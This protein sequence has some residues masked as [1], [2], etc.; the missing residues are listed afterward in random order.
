MPKPVEAAMIG[1]LPEGWQEKMLDLY[2][3]GASDAE[4]MVDLRMHARLWMQLL[5][6]SEFAEV[7][8]FGRQLAKAFWYSQARKNLC[9]KEFNATLYKCAMAN[10]YNWSD[11][12]SNHESDDFTKALSDDELLQK[13]QQKSTKLKAV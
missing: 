7:V 13:L 10:M 4:V 12:T 9:N 8:E 1:K 3:A 5:S 6:N 11:K 2:N